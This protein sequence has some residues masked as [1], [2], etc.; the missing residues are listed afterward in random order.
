MHAVHFDKPSQPDYLIV[1]ARQRSG[2]STLSSSLGG[3]PCAANANEI[4]TNNTSQ[5][6]LGGH[7]FT[8]LS[9]KDIR[10]KPHEFLSEIHSSLCSK[11]KSTGLVHETCSKCTIVLKMFDIHDIS[12]EGIIDLMSDKDVYFVVLERDVEQ[13]FCSLQ[14]AHQKGDWGTTPG[15]HKL[16]YA[17]TFDCGG[18]T[19]EFYYK[20]TLWF[21]FLRTEL[22]RNQRFFVDIPFDVISSCEIKE[23]VES[24][25]AFSGLELPVDFHYADKNIEN[26]FNMC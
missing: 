4:W 18:V 14:L 25:F 2:S 20:H 17:S 13:E 3:H 16:K 7:E 24:V 5:D 19:E 22:R 10:A 15:Q 21:N 23:A 11:A 8:S 26:V 1:A 12:S 9:P 6:I